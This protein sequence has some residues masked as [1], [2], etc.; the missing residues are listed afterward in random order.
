MEIPVKRLSDGLRGMLRL[1]GLLELAVAVALYA[2]VSGHWATFA[3][4]FLTP[5]IALLGYLVNARWGAA[6]Y[7]TTHSYIGPALLALVGL[8]AAPG[9]LAFAVIWA[10]HIGFDRALGYGLKSRDGFR[11]THLGVIGH[12][13]A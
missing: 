1:E 9:A 5:D 8:A 12:A 13:P 7:N 4:F 6:A 10:A 11:E 3:I 2:H